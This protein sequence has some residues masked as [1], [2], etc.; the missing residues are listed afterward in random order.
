MRAKF[1]TG[2][3]SSYGSAP[4]RGWVRKAPVTL[5]SIR[6]FWPD[7]DNP[8]GDS[9]VSNFMLKGAPGQLILDMNRLR[10]QSRQRVPRMS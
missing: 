5:L 8:S 3:R 4:W 1:T 2:L 6:F 10:I 9:C 7:P